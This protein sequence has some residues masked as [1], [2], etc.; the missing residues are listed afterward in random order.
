MLFNISNIL[1]ISSKMFHLNSILHMW[2]F[3]PKF[4]DTI[5]VYGYLQEDS[6]TMSIHWSLFLWLSLLGPGWWTIY[7]NEMA[8]AN[9][10]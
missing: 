10:W 8:R 5:L 1:K 2:N 6:V 4:D 9:S 7:A 3:I